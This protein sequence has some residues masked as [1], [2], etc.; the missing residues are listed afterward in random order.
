MIDLEIVEFSHWKMYLIANISKNNIP[1]IVR[2]GHSL[3]VK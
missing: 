3:I 1:N 2:C